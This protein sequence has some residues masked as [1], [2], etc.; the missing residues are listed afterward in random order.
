MRIDAHQQFWHYSAEEH[1]WIDDSMSILRH[2]F[3]PEHLEPELKQAGFDACIA[4]QAR[5][6]LEETRW[7]LNLAASSPLV[8][9][10]VGWVDL[11]SEGV[12][13]QLLEFASNPK[14]PRRAAH[15]S[16]RTRRPLSA[17]PEFLRGIAAS[18]VLFTTGLGT[19]TG[20]PRSKGNRRGHLARC[21]RRG[22]NSRHSRSGR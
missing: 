7:L 16:E 2:D 10:V 6:T 17:P 12:R 9:G 5:Q 3:L 20:N 4:V 11:Q 8:R 14:I 19:P 18:V 1:G 13:E 22:R 21:C 15:R